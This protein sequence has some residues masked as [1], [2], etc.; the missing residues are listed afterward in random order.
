MNRLERIEAAARQR[1]ELDRKRAELVELLVGE[2]VE[3]EDA[4]VDVE[5]YFDTSVPF[6]DRLDRLHEEVQKLRS[7]KRPARL[8]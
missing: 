3:L 8:M 4:G 7:A 5:W 2:F 6:R 1:A